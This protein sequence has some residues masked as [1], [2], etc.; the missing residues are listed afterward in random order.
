[1]SGERQSPVPAAGAAT[2]SPLRRC[3]EYCGVEATSEMRR[4]QLTHNMRSG[5]WQEPKY[6]CPKCRERLRGYFR[7][8][9]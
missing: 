1:M 6:I 4:V 9:I 2:S 7:Y 3:E 5:E 8:A